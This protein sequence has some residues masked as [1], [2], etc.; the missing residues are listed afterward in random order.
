MTALAPGLTETHLLDGARTA[1]PE[2]ARLLPDALVED[3]ATVAEEGY[4]ACMNG[5]VVHVPGLANRAMATLADVAPRAVI[6]RLAGLV[7]RRIV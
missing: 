3:P 4:S 7:G 5:E 6:R 1:I 2:V